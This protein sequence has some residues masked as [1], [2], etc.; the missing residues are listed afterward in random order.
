VVTAE[1]KAAIGAAHTKTVTLWR[2][3]KRMAT[4]VLDS[5]LESWPNPKKTLFE[6]I[7]VDTDEEAGVKLPK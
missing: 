7:G 4:D 2:K 3:R 1:E 5:I 6:D